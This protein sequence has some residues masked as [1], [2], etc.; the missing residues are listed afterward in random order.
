MDAWFKPWNV[1]GTLRDSVV[2]SDKCNENPLASREGIICG[3]ILRLIN[4]DYDLQTYRGSMLIVVKGE[5][6][7]PNVNY[8]IGPGT[9]I[10]NNTI[11]LDSGLFQ[12]TCFYSEGN[13]RFYRYS[14]DIQMTEIEQMC[15]YSV[16]GNSEAQYRFF[17]PSYNMNFN[18]ISVSCNGFSLSV[19]TTVFKGSLW[20]DI[21]KKHEYTRYHVILGGGDQIYSDS[22]KI[23]CEQFKK[24]LQMKDPIKKY[25]MKASTSF[26]EELNSFYLKEYLE[27][28]GFGYWKGAT[29]KSQT[30]QRCFPIASATIPS[31]NVFDDH[32]IID[33]YGSYSHSFMSTDVFKAVG[34][35]AYK[36]YMLFQHHTSIE[37]VEAYEKDPVWILGA[38]NG[39][40]ISEKSHSLFCRLGPDMAVLGIDCRTER[41]L[42]QICSKK[43]YDIIFERLREEVEEHELKHLLVML[44]VPVAYPRLVWLEKL[45]SSKLLA[46][47]KWLSKKGVIFRGLVNEFN[48]DV[49]VLDD[50]NDHW[51]AHNH[52]QERNFLVAKLQDFSAL[53]GVRITILSGDVHLAALGRFRSNYHTHGTGSQP[54]KDESD[55]LKHPELDVRL[56]FNVISSAV[57]NT[58]PPNQMAALLQKRS[59]KHHFDR[60]TDEDSVSIFSV[61]VDGTN[62]SNDSFMNRRNWSDIIP[63]E[64][65]LNNSSLND[66]YKL[67]IGDIITPGLVGNSAKF[68]TALDAGTNSY[69]VTKHGV[70]ATFH[71]ETDPQNLD[72]QT[73]NYSVVI[74]DLQ[75]TQEKLSHVGCKHLDIF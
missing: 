48:G 52:K 22:V 31:I 65:I 53:H 6:E 71:V 56:M 47:L 51:C 29:E 2:D 41:K 11:E 39:S 35:S 54:G 18:T 69:P 14:I 57:V 15:K 7:Q 37:E 30:S 13:L 59:K 38:E 36:Y 28:Y 66:D 17:I 16:D 24:W 49:E 4:V 33:G 74:P 68:S 72:S 42:K 34:S 1:E 21:L 75:K 50:L 60:E 63:V 61:D 25:S 19:D 27:W 23:Y 43:T 12:G 58:P 40:Y 44:G 64:N 20:Y 62:R 73:T 67:K 5:V 70:V 55:Y 8:E 3:P 45:F 10:A 46:P 26:K 32:D 9:N